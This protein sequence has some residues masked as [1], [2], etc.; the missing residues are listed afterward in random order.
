MDPRSRESYGVARGIRSSIFGFHRPGGCV[1]TRPATRF[2]WWRQS[3]AE[4]APRRKARADRPPA[5]IR[6]RR[7]PTPARAG[8]RRP[9]SFVSAVESRRVESC[10]QSVG[11]TAKMCP[12]RLPIRHTYP[13][14]N[15]ANAGLFPSGRYWARTNDLRLVEPAWGANN[16]A[17]CGRTLVFMRFSSGQSVLDRG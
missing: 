1:N 3:R 16:A 5:G 13:K 8:P 15:P 7:S 6:R 4:P 10:G 17:L 14:K 9:S 2:S 11:K 12:I